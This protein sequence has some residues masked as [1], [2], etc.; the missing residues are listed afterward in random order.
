MYKRTCKTYT[1]NQN[2]TWKIMSYKRSQV[3]SFESGKHYF[4]QVRW[5]SKREYGRTLCKLECVFPSLSQTNGTVVLKR[6][7]HFQKCLTHTRDGNLWNIIPSSLQVDVD[8]Q[9]NITDS[10]YQ[11][12]IGNDG[13]ILAIALVKSFD[14]FCCFIRFSRFS[15]SRRMLYQIIKNKIIG[16]MYCFISVCKSNM[17]MCL[18]YKTLRNES[19]CFK[20]YLMN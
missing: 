16:L 2:I 5:I 12:Y 4:H 7:P 14:C 15:F 13:I 10:T 20:A 11:L 19:L 17:T 18:L 1:C 3:K 6:S 8:K 9:C